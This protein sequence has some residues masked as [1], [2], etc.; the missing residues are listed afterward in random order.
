MNYLK[1]TVILLLCFFLL[2]C[3]IDEYYYLPQVPEDGITREVNTKADINIPSNLLNGVSHYATG[4][5]IFYKIYTSEIAN[6]NIEILR[7]DDYPRIKSDYNGLFTYTD[8]TNATSIPSLT[9]FSG[10][11]FYELELK[12]INIGTILSTNGGSFSINFQPITGV[13]PFIEYNDKKYILLRSNDNGKFNPKPDDR[14]FFSSDD[15]KDYENA[16]QKSPTINAD[17]SGQIGIP[18]NAFVSMY[19]VAVGSNPRNFTK[20]YGKPTHI[21]IFKLPPL[22]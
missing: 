18:Q 10:R 15:L 20:F 3:G 17:V 12:G 7:G 2:T 5:V 16:I 19:I 4:Y 14:Y 21:S 1:T 22:N 6:D 9:T 11:G 13:E 8:R